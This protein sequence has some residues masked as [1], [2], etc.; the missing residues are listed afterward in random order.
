MIFVSMDLPDICLAVSFPALP[1]SF[2]RSVN[3]E[4]REHLLSLV[5]EMSQLPRLAKNF[6]NF[7]RI[8]PHRLA[9]RP[10]SHSLFHHSPLIKEKSGMVFQL[11]ATLLE[12][13]DPLLSMERIWFDPLL[14]EEFRFKRSR[15]VVVWRRDWNWR[16]SSLDEVSPLN[17]T[18]FT[19]LRRVLGRAGSWWSRLE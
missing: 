2:S 14:V 13:K 5:L 12:P 19:S 9:V 4:L 6:W 10:I 17:F 15:V 8:L 18:P 3:F 7:F 16:D 11:H 1:F